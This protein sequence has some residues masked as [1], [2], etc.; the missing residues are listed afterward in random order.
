MDSMAAQERQEFQ[1]YIEAW[2]ERLAKQDRARQVRTQHLRR[3][4]RS[5]AQ[6]LVQDFGARKVYLFGSLLVEDLVHDRSDIDL[7]VEGLEGKQYFEALREVWTLLPAGVELDLVLLERAWPG[8]AERVRK[9]GVLL[10]A[11]S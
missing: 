2:R 4:A 9:E 5:C 10:D 6:R 1:E 11:V 7:A 8:L 3:I